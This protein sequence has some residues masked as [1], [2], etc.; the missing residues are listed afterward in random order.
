MDLMRRRVEAVCRRF[1]A[2]TPCF[3]AR[4]WMRITNRRT[5]ARRL[6][7]W[8]AGAFRRAR[9]DAWAVGQAGQVFADDDDALWISVIWRAD[10]PEWRHGDVCMLPDGV[11]RTVRNILNR[12]NIRVFLRLRRCSMDGLKIDTGDFE[13]ATRALQAGVRKN[14][15]HYAQALAAEAQ[16]AARANAAWVTVRALRAEAGQRR[17]ADGDAYDDCAWRQRTEQGEAQRV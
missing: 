15:L 12:G 11:K 3:R 9:P 16:R 1:P 6:A 5:K 8:N 7:L 14:V 4:F 13:R 2:E 17:G 10:L